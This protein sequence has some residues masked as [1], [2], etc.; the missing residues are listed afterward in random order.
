[1]ATPRSV[2]REMRLVLI[3]GSTF[4][5]VWPVTAHP[6]AVGA[7]EDRS[8]LARAWGSPSCRLMLPS[9]GAARKTRHLTTRELFSMGEANAL[10]DVPE[11]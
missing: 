1:M 5:C 9:R 11:I 8:R 2:C 3:S 6:V 10:H 7:S 4:E